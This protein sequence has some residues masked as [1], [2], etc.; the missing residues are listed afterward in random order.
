MDDDASLSSPLKSARTVLLVSA[1][2]TSHFARYQ[3]SVLCQRTWQNELQATIEQPES[4]VAD[5]P[6]YLFIQRAETVEER[7]GDRHNTQM[8]EQLDSKAGPDVVEGH[9]LA[10]I[11][12]DVIQ[13]LPD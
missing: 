1:S 8:K 12:F 6:S 2:S 7:D 9:Q 10:E 3:Y 4:R 5:E 13:G 11:V